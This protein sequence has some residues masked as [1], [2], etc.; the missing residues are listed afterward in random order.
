[1]R[2]KKIVCII[3]FFASVVEVAIA[4]PFGIDM[5]MSLEKLTEVT[6]KAPILKGDVYLIS[7]HKPHPLFETYIVRISKSRGVYFI[8]S[9]G[10]TIQTSIYGDDVKSGFQAVKDGLEKAYGPCSV[11][12]F[13]RSGSIWDEPEDW[14]M[15]LLKDERYLVASWG[16]QYGSKLP[17]DLSTIIIAAKAMSLNSGYIGVEY[18][19]SFYEEAKEEIKAEQDS[20]F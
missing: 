17:S 4:G 9:V 7:P 19:A 8:K 18:Y 1:M 2:L 15:A 12:D 6:G 16:V 14:M 11:I 3:S 20:V 5:G 10:K 13:L